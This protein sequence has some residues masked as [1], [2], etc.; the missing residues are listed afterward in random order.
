MNKEKLFEI[1][2]GEIGCSKAMKDIMINII[3]NWES[4]IWNSYEIKKHNKKIKIINLY[5]NKESFLLE[6]NEFIKLLE[7]FFKKEC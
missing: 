6:K 5:N 4:F 3:K 1:L 2:M 7:E